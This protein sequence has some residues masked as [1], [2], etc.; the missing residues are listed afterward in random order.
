MIRTLP[1]LLLCYALGACGATSIT[2]LVGED[3]E[4]LELLQATPPDDPATS[5]LAAARRLHQALIQ[6][7]KAGGQV[8]D[9]WIVE[10]EHSV[11]RFMM[12][13]SASQPAA[14][15]SAASP[16]HG[17]RVVSWYD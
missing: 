9:T 7:R 14:L 17:R 10:A 1:L 5:A 3:Q 16:R 4:V 8:Y 12:Q 11:A 2:P 13:Q 15:G 6:S